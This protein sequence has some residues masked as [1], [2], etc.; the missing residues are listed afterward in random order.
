MSKLDKLFKRKCSVCGNQYS[1]AF[2]N[3]IKLKTEDGVT[4][5]KIC[6]SCSD[7]LEQIKL[8]DLL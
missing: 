4:K 3:K 8:K 6:D 1:K 7:T 5:M 2:P